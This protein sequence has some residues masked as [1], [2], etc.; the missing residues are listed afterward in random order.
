MKKKR[1]YMKIVVT[2]ILLFLLGFTGLCLYLFYRTGGMEP[3][4]LIVS[5]FA[6]VMGE[7]SIC[8]LLKRSH[9]SHEDEA[10]QSKDQQ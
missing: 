8:G 6:A 1:N 9:K 10:E 4:T 7:L 5:V 3:S 2:A